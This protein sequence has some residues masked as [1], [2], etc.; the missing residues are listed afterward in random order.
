MSH[1]IELSSIST[2]P[3]KKANKEK[4]AAEINRLTEKL[5][6]IQDKLYAQKKYSILI[7]LQGMDTSGKDSAV[8]HV[9]SGVNPA[10]CNVT[11]FKIPSLEEASHHFLW[12]VS[13]ECPAKGMIHIFNRSH[14]EEI[15]MPRVNHSLKDE[16]LKGRCEEI[17]M[18]E[19]GLMD[20]NTIIFKFYLHISHKEQLQR[21]KA[22]ETEPKKQWKF[23]KEDVID[24]EKQSQYK[25]AY[26]FVFKHCSNPSPWII[27]P[28]DK[29]WYKNH[30]ILKSIVER[31][32]KYDINYPK[33]KA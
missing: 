32:E 2:L 19:K 29:K 33:L 31:L 26:E 13:K 1:H 20:D 10:G 25:H 12:R 28:S 5:V 17:N 3:K 14:Y 22:R 6:D 24:I 7:I 15:I 27:I 30:C 9:F 16:A 8:K 18:F 4:A 21:L 11:S 23:Q